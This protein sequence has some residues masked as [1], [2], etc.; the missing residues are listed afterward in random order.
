MATILFTFSFVCLCICTQKLAW[1]ALI[2]NTE[3]FGYQEHFLAVEHTIGIHSALVY[4]VLKEQVLIFIFYSWFMTALAVALVG[5][6]FIL[7]KFM[8]G[9]M[10][11]KSFEA[12]EF[13]MATIASLNAVEYRLFF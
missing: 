11:S 3:C 10:L 9:D 13:S 2:P 5:M 8:A 12:F 7:F 1:F 6:F 4:P